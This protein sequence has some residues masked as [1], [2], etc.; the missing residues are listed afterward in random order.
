MIWKQTNKVAK[1]HEFPHLS[2]QLLISSLPANRFFQHLPWPLRRLVRGIGQGGYQLLRR[3]LHAGLRSVLRRS[4]W[5]CFCVQK[6]KIQDFTSMYCTICYVLYLH[7]WYL[8]PR[9]PLTIR[10]CETYISLPIASVATTVHDEYEDN[11]GTY[12]VIKNNSDK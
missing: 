2:N 6:T 3:V 10:E 5:W 12:N 1:R 7:I 8:C 4:S 11:L 9:T